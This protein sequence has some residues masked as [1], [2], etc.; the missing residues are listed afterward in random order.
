MDSSLFMGS[1]DTKFAFMFFQPSTWLLHQNIQTVIFYVF[2]QHQNTTQ[3][4]KLTDSQSD[5]AIGKNRTY[6]VQFEK[7][8]N[9]VLVN[10]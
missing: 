7:K 10:L 8:S 5:L 3:I 2:F 6:H 4:G 1:N 9:T